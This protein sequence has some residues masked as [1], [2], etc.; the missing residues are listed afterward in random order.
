MQVNFNPKV[1]YSR[2][3]FKASFSDDIETKLIF[4]SLNKSNFEQINLLA[5]HYALQD[6]TSND[7]ISLVNNYPEYTIC[8][9]NLTNGK[10]IELKG[11]PACPDKAVPARLRK[12]IENG[13][14]IDEK[15]KHDMETYIKKAAVF[16]TLNSKKENSKADKIKQLIKELEN[17][18]KMLQDKLWKVKDNESYNRAKAVEKEVFSLVKKVK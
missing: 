1:N 18:L 15:P 5:V 4:D 3:N 9:K 8:A 12:A 6:M 13:N 14:L 10:E 7:K 2:P 11:Y 17:E 16:L